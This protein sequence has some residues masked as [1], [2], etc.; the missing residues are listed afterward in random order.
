MILKSHKAKFAKK[1][2]KM[3]IFILVEEGYLTLPCFHTNSLM[4]KKLKL[5]VHNGLYFITLTYNLL[6]EPKPSFHNL[7]SI[8]SISSQSLFIN[9]TPNK[10]CI[11]FYKVIII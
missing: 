3:M 1:K 5:S 7:F 2:T 8:A 10:D 9:L 6:N 11:P 4:H